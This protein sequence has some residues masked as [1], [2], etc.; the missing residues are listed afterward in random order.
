MKIVF[1]GTSNVALPV[2]ETLFRHHDVAAVVT[3]PDKKVGRKREIQESP[4]SVLA[5]EMHIP[6][7]KPETVKGNDVLR[8]QLESIQADVFIVVS[9]GKILPAEIIGMPR[10]K[11]L[12][13]HFSLLPKYRG[14][15]PIQ[16]ALLNGDTKTGTTIFVLDEAMDHGPIL[17]QQ[18]AGIDSDDNFIT[19]SEKM[20]HASAKLLMDVLPRYESGEIKPIAQDDSQATS[21]PIITKADGKI[22]WQ[23]PAVE[24]YN[25]FRAFYPW[26]GIW[27]TWNGKQIKIL[28]CAA[29]S[30]SLPTQEAPGTVLDNG[31]VA[32]GNA[33]G[34]EIS[35][36]QLEGKN[37]V[38][39][40]D[41]LNGYPNFVNSQLE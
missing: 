4:V 10:L 24:I 19:L 12:N 40:L 35:T 38:G 33:T 25:Q 2:L 37:E 23:K 32:C 26:P 6:L 22:N 1:F 3:Q 17:A 13:V 16:Q 9:Y 11:T 36:L 20:A 7:L 41:F 30:A 18:E 15:S 14:S 21:A 5:N 28:N 29:A 34:L 8:V 27:T 31:L 39:I